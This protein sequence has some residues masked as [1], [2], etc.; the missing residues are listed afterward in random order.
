MVD[1]TEEEINGQGSA[2]LSLQP[3][4]AQI[5]PCWRYPVDIILMIYIYIY[6]YELVQR[7]LPAAGT[8][9]QSDTVRNAGMTRK[10]AR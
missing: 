4:C 8:P 1:R 2:P 9:C 10:K 3:R 7:C 6:I 5:L